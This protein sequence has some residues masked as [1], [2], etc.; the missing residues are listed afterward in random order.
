MR[1]LSDN[2][3]YDKK[4]IDE[5]DV[6]YTD[7]VKTGSRTAP[8]AVRLTPTWNK[9]APDP[10]PIPTTF[11]PR[12]AY[13]KPKDFMTHGYIGNCKDVNTSLQEREAGRTTVLNAD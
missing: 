8:I 6:K 2:E 4:C 11:V 7:Y 12:A 9:A 13:L 1:R 10:N 3:A 5:I